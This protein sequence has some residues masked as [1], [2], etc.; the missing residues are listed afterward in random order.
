MALLL[1]SR[2][3]RAL[4]QAFQ[5]PGLDFRIMLAAGAVNVFLNL[6]LVPRLGL[7]GA[8]ATSV[9]CETLILAASFLAARRVVGDATDVR[10]LAG[11]LACAAIMAV[12]VHFATA[13][14]LLARMAFGAAVYSALVLAFRVVSIEDLR[15][16]L[17]T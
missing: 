5:R 12:A 16:A 15:E 9:T 14:P 7:L 2:H 4:L 6:L 17:R 1:V 10:A 11:S 3:Y 8:A 13:L